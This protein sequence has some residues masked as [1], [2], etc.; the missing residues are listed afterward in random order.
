MPSPCRKA[1]VGHNGPDNEVAVGGVPKVL[2][3]RLA[4]SIKLGDRSSKASEWVCFGLA[5]STSEEWCM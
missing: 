3:L 4:V 5:Q 1:L 2:F